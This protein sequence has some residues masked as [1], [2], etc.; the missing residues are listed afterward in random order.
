MVD[1][2]STEGISTDMM[3]GPVGRR[4]ESPG[5]NLLPVK[6]VPDGIPTHYGWKPFIAERKKNAEL[7]AVWMYFGT[8]TGI[9]WNF[10]RNP[11]EGAETCSNPWNMVRNMVER[12]GRFIASS[13]SI[14]EGSSSTGDCSTRPIPQDGGF[15]ELFR[16]RG[17]PWSPILAFLWWVWTTW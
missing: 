12:C 2:S 5:V 6:Q 14:F 16:R 11:Q 1:D 13:I 17:L 9:L 7:R 8:D 4:R 10:S 3:I 15:R